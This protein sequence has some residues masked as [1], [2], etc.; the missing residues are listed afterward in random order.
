M[1]ANDDMENLLTAIPLKE[2]F[3]KDYKIREQDKGSFLIHMHRAE[4]GRLT[5]YRTRLDTT[6]Y[7]AM[8]S[9]G[10]FSIYLINQESIPHYFYIFIFA[11]ISFYLMI[12]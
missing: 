10:L 5:L 12:E 6:T 1:S 11:I 7:W 4:V 8:S 9:L 2:S 3:Y